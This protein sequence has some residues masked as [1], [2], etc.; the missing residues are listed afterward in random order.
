ML[1]RTLDAIYAP[2][3]RLHG[4]LVNRIIYPHGGPYN[5]YNTG[6]WWERAALAAC[7]RCMLAMAKD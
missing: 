1:E 5:P 3:F 6:A 2:L 4:R 7:K